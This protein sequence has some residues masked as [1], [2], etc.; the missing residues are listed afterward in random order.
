[1]SSKY[2]QN[3]QAISSIQDIQMDVDIECPAPSAFDRVMDGRAVSAVNSPLFKIP[4]EILG[5]I[6]NHIATSDLASL[7][8]VNSDCRQ[9]AR[10]R[11]FRVVNLDFSPQFECMLGLLHREAVERR[12]HPGLTRP[13]SLGACIRRIVTYNDRYCNIAPPERPRR[14][15]VYD[16]EEIGVEDLDGVEENESQLRQWQTEWEALN[17]KLKEL[18]L[19]GVVFILPSLQHLE[20]LEM[21][22]V[23]WNQSLLN[24]LT[25]SSIRHLS[26]RNLRLTDIIPFMDE[27]VR[28]LL[29]TLDI[30]L[31]W[32]YELDNELQRPPTGI[33]VDKTWNTILRLCSSS[34]RF[35]RLSHEPVIRNL[36]AHEAD[37]S[38]SYQ[39]PLLRELDIPWGTRFG[40]SALQSLIFTSPRLSTL[41]VNYG[42]QA[43]REFL[44]LNGTIPSL[45]TLVLHTS[46]TSNIPD[47]ASMDFLKNN[48]QLKALGFSNQKASLLEERV[49]AH[50]TAFKGLT[51]L[52]MIWPS[53][54]NVIPDSSLEHVS[55]ISSL[56][57]LHLSCGYQRGVV[58]NWF[59]KHDTIIQLLKPLAALT[60]LAFT[61]DTYSYYRDGAAIR[62]HY[63]SAQ[64]SEN[65][66]DL[67]SPAMHA[68]ALK[69]AKAFPKLEFIHIGEI[70]FRVR[71]AG[72]G[73]EVNGIKDV[74]FSWRINMFGMRTD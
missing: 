45:A 42:D 8:L 58:P 40:P 23:N 49:L 63:N 32:H 55:K 34:L 47:D 1:V 17:K 2:T 26:L 15:I 60:Q 73:V 7:A 37:V 64:H 74:K 33:R 46:S 50:L 67:H 57:I 62:R 52:S 29:E 48:S 43:T 38:F 30:R 24:N 59:P 22:A 66:W 72:G 70:S 68:E 10:S 28:W 25:A 54:V 65:I 31:I 39:L 21:T 35:L 71:R 41:N 36:G 27:S 16:G 61:C 53:E 18:Y 9:L 12:Q 13:P 56:A 69:Y 20:S 11:Q 3:I 4:T 51:R 6:L 19:P 44:D 5:I 14:P